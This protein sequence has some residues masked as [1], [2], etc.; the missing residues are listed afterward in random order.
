MLCIR[1]KIFVKEKMNTSKIKESKYKYYFKFTLEISVREQCIFS[2]KQ[3][4]YFLILLTKE[5]Y[6]K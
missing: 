1:T 4:M 3:K 6:K 5:V 2:F